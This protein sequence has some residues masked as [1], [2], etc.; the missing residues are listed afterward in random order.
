MTTPRQ[1]AFSFIPPPRRYALV[2]EWNTYPTAYGTAD[3]VAQIAKARAQS[4]IRPVGDYMTTV[5]EY[6]PDVRG[7]AV[8]P[9]TGVIHVAV[10]SPKRDRPYKQGFVGHRHHDWDWNDPVE[11]LVKKLPV[12]Q[13]VRERVVYPQEAELKAMPRAERRKVWE[14]DFA[15]RSGA[16]EEFSKALKHRDD[17]ANERVLELY[18]ALRRADVDIA[19]RLEVTPETSFYTGGRLFR[20]PADYERSFLDLQ[21]ARN[22]TMERKGAGYLIIAETPDG[23]LYTRKIR[24]SD[25]AMMKKLRSFA[26][27]VI[28]RGQPSSKRLFPS[29]RGF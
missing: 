13:R 16:Y 8:E 2:S 15:D 21:A 18:A 5:T 10:P 7:R 3:K 19:H 23:R 25:G 17:L 20:E 28:D 4:S 26:P 22:R 29:R 6:K 12:E 27:P 1:S 24:L 9:W 14:A 11:A